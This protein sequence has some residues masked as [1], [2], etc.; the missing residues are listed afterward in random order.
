[1]AGAAQGDCAER[2]ASG[3]ASGCRHNCR[4]RPIRRNPVGGAVARFGCEPGQRA[5]CGRDRAR[6][7][8][9][10]ALSQWRTDRDRERVGVVHRDLMVTLAAQH[11]LPAVYSCARLRHRW[12]PDLLRADIRPVPARRRL[13]RS[14]PQGREACRPAGAGT[15]QVRARRSTSRRPRRSASTCR[16]RCSPAPTR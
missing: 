16:S 1:M 7:R 3:G 8:G 6:R 15:D 11:K 9:L 5:R 12:R 4:D 14:H 13:R 2:D 10:R